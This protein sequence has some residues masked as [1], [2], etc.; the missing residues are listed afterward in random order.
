MVILCKGQNA[1]RVRSGLCVSV[2]LQWVFEPALRLGFFSVVTNFRHC[3]GVWTFDSD[4]VQVIIKRG[5]GEKMLEK[6]SGSPFICCPL[7]E[8]H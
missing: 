5:K 2:L 1:V 4:C 6:H 3:I 7:F 8:V